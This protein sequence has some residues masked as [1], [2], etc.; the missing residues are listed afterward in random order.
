MKSEEEKE[1]K[2]SSVSKG[3]PVKTLTSSE[4]AS[5]G[6]STQT[7]KGDGVGFS[8][9]NVPPLRTTGE[10]VFSLTIVANKP[11]G[12]PSS[13]MGEVYSFPHQRIIFSFGKR[14]IATS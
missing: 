3:S 5:A 2:N 14:V 4:S 1:N 11:L 8:A 12:L 13:V 10:I 7:S 9:D 6:S